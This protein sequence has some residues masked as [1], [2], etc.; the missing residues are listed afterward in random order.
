MDARGKKTAKSHTA[1]SLPRALRWL[2]APA[3]LLGLLVLVALGGKAA[4][5]ESDAATNQGEPAAADP[6]SAAPSHPAATPG[7]RVAQAGPSALE[8]VRRAIE[9]RN[10]G[11]ASDKKAFAAAG[12]TMVDVAPPDARLVAIDPSLL[13]SREAELRV[14]IAS[15]T[16]TPAEAQNLA[17]VA[18]RASEEQTRVAA[19][20][21]LGRLGAAGQ[22]QLTGLLDQLPEGDRAR[23]EIVPLL[24]PESLDSP[25]AADLASRLDSGHLDPAERK[26]AAFT[27][28]LVGL[29]DQSALPDTVLS[30][31]SADSRSLLDSM[32]RLAAK[33]SLENPR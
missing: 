1:R 30:T 26:Q 15:T 10:R 12:W 19:V 21:A 29:R 20:E 27:L 32:I 18:R 4:P 5:G 13:A 33:A 7:V 9:E 6:S 16:A 8:Q 17:E 23:R 31:L 28:A 25:L 11:P 14:Q 3:A 22:Q 2:L 24:R